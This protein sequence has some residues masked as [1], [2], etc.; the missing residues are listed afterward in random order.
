M[1][2]GYG[3]ILSLEDV[4]EI[5]SI[6]KNTAYS[7]LNTKELQGFKI[8]HI[9]KIPKYSLESYIAERCHSTKKPL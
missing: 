3:D 5:L 9:W 4:C 6:G 2:N 1:I 7:M 8:G